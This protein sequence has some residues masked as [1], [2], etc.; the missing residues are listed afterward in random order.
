MALIVIFG[1]ILVFIAGLALGVFRLMSGTDALQ[2]VLMASPILAST[3]LAGMSHI[4]N[5]K[6]GYQTSSE[7]PFSIVLCLILPTILIAIILA[8][9]I[10]FYVQVDGFGPEQLKITLGAIETTLGA[11]LGAISKKLFGVDTRSGRKRKSA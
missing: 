9:F 6:A 11:F 3:A 7:D 2:T 8:V 4:L 1:H 10:L 5:R